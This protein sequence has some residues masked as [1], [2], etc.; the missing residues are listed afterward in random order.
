MWFAIVVTVLAATGNNIGKAL[1]KE[2]VHGLPRFSLYPGIFRQ[3]LRSRL[4]LIGLA[5]DLS[6]ALLMIGAF[7]LAPVS[8]P[9]ATV[10]SPMLCAAEAV[11][12]VSEG[13]LMHAGLSRAAC[14]RSGLGLT[15]RVL[16]LPP[17]G[18]AAV[19]KSN[20]LLS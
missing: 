14:L 5:A 8:P 10:I 4:W 6:G 15:G 7:A 20:A 9:H 12:R 17:Q 16:P 13:F 11:A 1:Q 19:P 3:Y 2:A 18:V